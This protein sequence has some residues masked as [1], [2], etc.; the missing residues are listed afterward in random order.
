MAVSAGYAGPVPTPV[1]PLPR[2]IRARIA[3]FTLPFFE[4][5]LGFECTECGKCCRV[6]GDVWLSPEEVAGVSALLNIT[7]KAFREQHV[8]AV[9][10]PSDAIEDEEYEGSWMCLKKKQHDGSCTFLKESGQCAIYSARPIQCESYPFWP[11]ILN[12]MET[13][14]DEAVVPDNTPLRSGERYW[15]ADEGGCEGIIAPSASSTSE[16]NAD[17]RIVERQTIVAKMKAARKQWRRFPADEIK[18]T[19][20]F[21]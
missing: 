6:S 17:V 9:L 21:L 13:W 3:P 4:D 15:N 7:A 2:R 1:A 20:W 14:E 19:S 5:G 12:S 18:E 11:S 16:N 8:R 10:S